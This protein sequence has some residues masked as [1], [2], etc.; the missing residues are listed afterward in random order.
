MIPKIIHYT[1]FSGD[2]YPEKI[3][4]CIESWKKFLPDYEL[5]LWDMNAIKDI[6]SIFLKEALSV[7]KWAYAADFVRLHA[8]YHEGGIYLDTDVMVYKSFDDLLNNLCF[9][10]K[11]NSM[12]WAFDRYNG[13]QYLSSH[14]MG[15][16]KGHPF[17]KDCLG[18]Y[19]DRHFVL[20]HNESLPLCLRYNYVLL[21]YVQAI[22]AKEYGYN[23][24]PAVQKIQNCDKGL[25]VYPTD[26]FCGFQ[27][28]KESYCRHYCFG[29]WLEN[30][31]SKSISQSFK[32]NLLKRVKRII[33]KF[34][35]Y[36]SFTVMK[37]DS[38]I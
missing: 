36:F 29:G 37:V 11:E 21:P 22:I 28:L 35:L 6:N 23:W 26:W 24:N 34:T 4:V 14:C 19:L 7:K 17:I 30:V 13:I 1:W 2:E 10:G 18:Y 38:E 33:R 8:L 16:E 5:R 9:I 32:E 20:S 15:A 31:D 12:H 27:F 3:K 25:T